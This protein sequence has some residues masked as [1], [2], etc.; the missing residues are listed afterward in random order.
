M[1][2]SITYAPK[3]LNE[4]IYPNVAVQ[5]R[6]NAYANRKIEGHIILHGPNGTGK[7]TVANLLPYAIDGIDA[8]VEHKSFDEVLNQKD[9]KGYL[10]SACTTNQFSGKS[11]FYLVFHEFD[12]ATSKLNKLWTAMDELEDKLMLIITTNEPMKIHQSIRSRCDLIEMK[13]LTAQAMLSRAQQILISEGIKLPNNQ[14]LYYLKQW[15]NHGDLRK[16][17]KCLDELI[18]MHSAGIPFPAVPSISAPNLSVVKAKS[19]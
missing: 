13:A 6:I 1:K 10:Q 11:K 9:L 12:N 14:V 4:V 3:N 16:Y 17:L 18:F 15:E 7:T 5:R 19:K 2:T 8:D